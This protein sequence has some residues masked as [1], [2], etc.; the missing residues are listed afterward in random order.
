MYKQSEVSKAFD[1]GRADR[2]RD[3]VEHGRRNGLKMASER[4]PTDD[5]LFEAYMQGWDAAAGLA[6]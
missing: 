2:I 3:N 6:A 5:D 4:Y 1:Q